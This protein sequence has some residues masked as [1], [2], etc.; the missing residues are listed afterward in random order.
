MLNI[1]MPQ[2]F[3][4]F[5]FKYPYFG[6]ILIKGVNSG[7]GRGKGER[8]KG[9]NMRRVWGIPNPIGLRSAKL[10]WASTHTCW[11]NCIMGKEF[12]HFQNSQRQTR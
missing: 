6:V 12:G 11:K 1:G 2:P 7:G 4:R 10:F 5:T 8:G 9:E 3:S